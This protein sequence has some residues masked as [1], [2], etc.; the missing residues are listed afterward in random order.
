MQSPNMNAAPKGIPL[1]AES[2]ITPIIP[3]TASPIA[4]TIIAFPMIVVYAFLSRS[5]TFL[6][7]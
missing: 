3:E 5:F 6:T 7:W 4:I 1:L 2:V